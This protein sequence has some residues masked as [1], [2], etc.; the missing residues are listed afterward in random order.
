M[1]WLTLVPEYAG[2]QRLRAGPD[3][4]VPSPCIRHCRL[5]DND[6]CLGCFRTVEEIA[7]WSR[8]SDNTKRRILAQV[9]ARKRQPGHI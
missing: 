8:S 6:T 1:Q 4:T 7:T 3:S 2:V 5:D 9:A